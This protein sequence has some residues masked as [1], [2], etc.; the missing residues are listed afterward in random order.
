MSG[1]RPHR[2]GSGAITLDMEEMVD[3]DTSHYV[4]LESRNRLSR[5]DVSQRR[6][7]SAPGNVAATPGFRRRSRGVSSTGSFDRD[8]IQWDT[9][10]GPC[11]GV[12]REGH[13]D[14]RC[15]THTIR[16]IPGNGLQ[17]GAMDGSRP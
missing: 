8:P 1:L 13:V 15:H 7:S 10:F 2:Y 14:A 6:N 12:G 17:R 11:P 3:A 4:G 16:G 9:A 5:I